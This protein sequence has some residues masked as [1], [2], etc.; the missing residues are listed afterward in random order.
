MSETQQTYSPQPL[1][2]KPDWL[3]NSAMLSQITDGTANTMM[4]GESSGAGSGGNNSWTWTGGGSDAWN[5]ASWYNY[6]S[7]HSGGSQFMFGDGSVRNVADS[8]S[9]ATWSAL[10]SRGGGEVVGGDW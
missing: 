2:P 4:I 7:R 10:G 3:K 1:F 5:N 6:G 9:P 8:V